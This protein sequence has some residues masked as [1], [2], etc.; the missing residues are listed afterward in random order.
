MSIDQFILGLKLRMNF[1]LFFFFN[2]KSYLTINCNMK[3]ARFL[4]F[5]YICTENLEKPLAMCLSCSKAY[6]LYRIK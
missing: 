1:V 2:L 4:P 3:I 6:M 5:Y